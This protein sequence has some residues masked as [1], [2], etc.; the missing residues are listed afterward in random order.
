[1]RSTV[2]RLGLG[3]PARERWPVGQPQACPEEEESQMKQDINKNNIIM[4]C[5]YMYHK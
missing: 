4:S 2:G 5:S 3:P 1:M